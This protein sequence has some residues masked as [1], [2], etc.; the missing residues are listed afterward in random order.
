MDIGRGGAEQRSYPWGNTFDAA[1]ANTKE[2]ELNQ[3]TPVH[4]YPAGAT[5]EGLFDLAGNVWEWL[6]ERPGDLAGGAFYSEESEVGVSLRRW[7]YPDGWS[8]AVG[9]RCFVVPISHP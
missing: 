7:R 6:L 3:P 5:P 4:T 1:K 2:S 8:S 9:F